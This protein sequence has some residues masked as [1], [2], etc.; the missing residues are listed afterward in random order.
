MNPYETQ[1]A[2]A[3][4][5]LLHFGNAD[6]VLGG[7][8]GPEAAI[9]F[10]VRCVRELLD[11]ATLPPDARALDVGCA[12]GG[13]SFELTRACRSVTGLDFS[14]AFI[15]AAETLRR[16]GILQ[17]QITEEGIRTRSFTAV[18]P[19]GADRSRARF[20]QADACELPRDLGTFHVVLAAN[21]ICRLPQPEVFLARV[22]SL[23]EPG[24]QLL[25]TSPLTWLDEFTPP[26]HWI[27]GTPEK[28]SLDA[29]RE[30]LAPAFTLELQTDLPFLIREHARKFQYGIACGTR[31]RRQ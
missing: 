3:E 4:Y 7:L 6:D 23:V 24:G 13:S 5:L 20:S 25:L 26:E 9:G 18:V 29:L 15:R 21:L 27:G 28:P 2:V 12:V 17:T 14:A 8:P 10:P 1:R 30:L 16:E 31:W 19:P 22:Q 11:P